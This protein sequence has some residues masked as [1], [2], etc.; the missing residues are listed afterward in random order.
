MWSY[1][2]LNRDSGGKKRKVVD[3]K[4]VELIWLGDELDGIKY[5]LEIF[6]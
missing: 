4:D 3:F 5:C 1:E 6:V 2:M